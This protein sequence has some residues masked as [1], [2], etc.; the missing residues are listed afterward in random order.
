MF[1]KVYTNSALNP[2]ILILNGQDLFNAIK[3]FKPRRDAIDSWRIGMTY[4]LG[5]LLKR[6]S[7]WLTRSG[8]ISK[9]MTIPAYSA[10]FSTFSTLQT[11]QQRDRMKGGNIENEE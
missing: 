4:L 6:L 11:G 7:V 8:D 10:F 1:L 9:C 2:D 3:S 5:R